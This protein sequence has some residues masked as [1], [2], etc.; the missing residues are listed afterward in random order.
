MR[1]G[2]MGAELIS[3]ADS[4]EDDFYVSA[5][6]FAVGDLVRMGDRAAEDFRLRHPEI[7]EEAVQPLKW[8]STFDYKY[9]LSAV[10]SASSS[11]S[12]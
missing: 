5:A 12:G 4:L 11:A 3:E 2:C 10:V 9:S 8:C 1:P 6:R 7:A